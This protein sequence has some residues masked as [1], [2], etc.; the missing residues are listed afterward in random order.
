MRSTNSGL[1]GF[2]MVMVGMV[3]GSMA[4]SAEE[5]ALNVTAP[6]V[7]PITEPVTNAAPS[8]APVVET[9]T[10]SVATPVVAPV[11]A[12]EVP[13]LN[14]G[15]KWHAASWQVGTRVTEVKLM[16]KTRGTPGNGSYFGTIT[17]ITEQ[18]D[19][20]PSRL[21]LQ[22]R[23]MQSP[24]WLGVTYDHVR[25]ITM[26]DGNGD[27]IPD[28]SG[29]DGTEDLQVV[30]PYL[31]GTWDNESR[32]TPYAQV[33]VAICQA[34][35]KPNSWGD[36]HQR[37]VDA[38]KNVYGI[39]LAGGLSVR[40]YKSISADLFIKYAHVSDIT[41][42]WYYNYGDNYGGPFVMTMSYMAYGAGLNWRF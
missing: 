41:G 23:L 24:L 33:G 8:V 42:D 35:F 32:F 37:Y 14:E 21:Y 36:N 12:P 10:N 25:A 22:Y 13:P 20:V 40:L 31:Q 7:A 26:D 29:G 28:R 27:G 5:P 18:Q 16:N 19:Y 38:K 6:A 30:T 39:D 17:E 1:S 3:A 4:V 11:P 2:L 15:A 9:P 34:K